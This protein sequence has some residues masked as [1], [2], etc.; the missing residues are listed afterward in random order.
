MRTLLCPVGDGSR[1]AAATRSAGADIS[2]LLN[3]RHSQSSYLHVNRNADITAGTHYE[4]EQQQAVTA[5]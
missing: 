5:M 2:W 3:K 4:H 1:A